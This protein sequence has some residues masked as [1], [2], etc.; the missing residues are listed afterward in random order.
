MADF[1]YQPAQDDPLSKLRTAMASLDGQYLSLRSFLPIELSHKKNSGGHPRVSSPSR[2][3]GLHHR[4]PIRHGRRY[5]PA[6]RRA[7]ATGGPGLHTTKQSSPLPTTHFQP[8]RH[9]P[10]LQVRRPWSV[11]CTDLCFFFHGRGS[12]FQFQGEPDVHRYYCRRRE[13]GR[14]EGETHQ[15]GALEGLRANVHHIFR[16]SGELSPS[17]VALR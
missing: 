10:E 9:I 12:V 15:Q 14:G 13:N 8:A 3:G 1:Q 17:F 11:K 4:G 5:R 6:S 2:N 16:E 7:D